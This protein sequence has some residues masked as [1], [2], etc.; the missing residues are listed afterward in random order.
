MWTKKSITIRGQRRWNMVRHSG[1]MISMLSNVLTQWSE[2]TEELF[3]P[4]ALWLCL[5]NFGQKI[6][7]G[8]IRDIGVSLELQVGKY[9]WHVV[10]ISGAIVRGP[11][12]GVS[13]SPSVSLKVTATC[14]VIAVAW[15]TEFT[16]EQTLL[17]TNRPCHLQSIFTWCMCR[18][19]RV[20]TSKNVR[21][22]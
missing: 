15:S 20:A 2:R 17:T 19:C 1:D 4:P 5:V 8:R 9:R 21:S 13:S 14:Y 3:D 18:S 7:N 12:V 11:M 6:I 10:C 16:L 22:Q